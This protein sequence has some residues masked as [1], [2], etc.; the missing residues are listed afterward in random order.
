MLI[1]TH[2]GGNAMQSAFMRYFVCASISFLL[3][4]AVQALPH[5]D[6][7]VATPPV[8][9]GQGNADYGGD[10]TLVCTGGTP[11]NAGTPIPFFNIQIFFN[12]FVTSKLLAPNWT[13]ALLLVDEPIPPAAQLVC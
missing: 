7:N 8:L 12:T 5:C 9:R 3:P 1:Q 4:S 10:I 6:V 13:E 11:G 2:P